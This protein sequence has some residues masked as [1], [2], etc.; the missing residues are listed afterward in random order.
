MHLW[1][2]YDTCCVTAHVRSASLE[3]YHHRY[4][5]CQPPRNAATR[6]PPQPRYIS[7]ERHTAL[8]PA[9]TT[10]K[11]DAPFKAMAPRARPLT[12][13][14]R[15]S[16][17]QKRGYTMYANEYTA[18]GGEDSPEHAHACS[19]NGSM[20]TVLQLR[21]PVNRT[22]SH[23]KHV[24]HGYHVRCEE[25]RERVYFSQGHNLEAWTALMPTPLNNY[26]IRSLLGESVFN[27]P[28]EAITEEHLELAKVKLLQQYDVLLV[29]EDAELTARAVPY[30][31]GWHEYDLH[32][33]PEHADAVDGLP[34]QDELDALTDLNRLDEQLY[35][36][37]V[38]LARLDGVMYDVAAAAGVDL[39]PA[40]WLG[41]VQELNDAYVPRVLGPGGHSPSGSTAHK[42]RSRSSYRSYK[43]SRS[44][45]RRALVHE[46]LGAVGRGVAR[47][48]RSLAV[49]AA[50]GGYEG[51]H[52]AATRGNGAQCGFVSH[53]EK[54]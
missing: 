7:G 14:E 12:C 40:G 6:C 36:Y 18:L 21:R 53:G 29:L 5:A 11:C 31:M 24:W 3:R 17:L 26:L 37:G 9:N 13:E 48:L 41:A 43:S 39:R 2:Q 8:K 35:E 20:L 47:V 52:V 10:T 42:H 22:L 32:A 54:N 38:V 19:S 23:I 4:P 1:H 33:N 27:L 51:S 34:E 44:H 16:V 28:L 50:A 49:G 46:R 30:G 25:D 45:A 15:V